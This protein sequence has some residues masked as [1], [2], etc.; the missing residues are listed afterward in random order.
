MRVARDSAEYQ[1]LLAIRFRGRQPQFSRT[2]N[3]FWICEIPDSHV[4]AGVGESQDDAAVDFAN[5]YE[6]AMGAMHRVLA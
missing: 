4:L 1:R 2:P 5:N 6:L 3:Y